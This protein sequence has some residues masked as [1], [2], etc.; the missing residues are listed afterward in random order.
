MNAPKEG[1]I[2]SKSQ[3]ITRLSFLHGIQFQLFLG[4]VGHLKIVKNP[5]APMSTH[6]NLR[7]TTLTIHL[8]LV[9]VVH[10]FCTCNKQI[11]LF[12][13]EAKE[14]IE[15]N[16]EHREQL[17]KEKKKT[18]QLLDALRASERESLQH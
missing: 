2:S 4:Q 8:N 13:I 7:F 12:G 18:H 16:K 5:S 17:E 11:T 6:Y 3:L 9:T 10:S 15:F 1:A 14:N